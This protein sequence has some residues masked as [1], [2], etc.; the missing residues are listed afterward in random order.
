MSTFCLNVLTFRFIRAYV[1]VIEKFTIK[2]FVTFL[3]RIKSTDNLFLR[4]QKNVTKL[5]MIYMKK[6]YNILSVY[7]QVFRYLEPESP[8]QWNRVLFF[9]QIHSTR[10][11]T[12]ERYNLKVQLTESDLPEISHTFCLD[13]SRYI[14]I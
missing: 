3:S 4:C 13:T 12:Y 10:Q 11:F 1:S 5:K 8:F 9:T 6:D 14:L 2:G 7:I